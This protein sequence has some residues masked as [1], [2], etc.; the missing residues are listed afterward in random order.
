MTPEQQTAL[1]TAR[2]LLDLGY[3]LD[4]VLTNPLI[5]PELREFVRTEL[6]REENITLTPARILVRDQNRADWLRGLDRSAWY[7]WPTLRQ[8]LL[9]TKGWDSSV[10]RSLDDSSDRILRQLEPPST[11]RFD[12]RGLVLGFVQSGKTANF[13]AVAAKAADAGYRLV[14]VLSGIDNSLRRQ[15]NIRLKRELVGYPDNRPGSVHLPPMGLQWHE[16]TRDDLRGDFRP[17]FANHAA[18]QGSQPVLLVVKKNGHV[19]RRLLT[20]LRQAP[21]EVRHTLPVLV[22]DDEADLASV[23][24]CGTY[25][26]AEDPPDTSDPDYEPP[27]AI[28]GL[29]RELLGLFE[30]RVYVAYTATPYAN[31]LIP[32]DT[33][34]PRVRND[35]YPKDFIVDLPKPAGY[36]G[37]EEIFGRM[38]GAT[39]TE[40]GG[41]DVIREMT[42]EDIA[43]LDQDQL[44]ASLEAAL[45]DF[46]LAGAARAQRGQDNTPATMLIHT[47]QLIMV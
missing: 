30:R 28:N 1:R 6:Q 33:E 13:T 5:T 14:I 4:I 32:H 38:D 45:L 40:V 18:L 19:L 10:L 20:W 43:A 21:V 44:P 46:V 26:T 22:I 17:G 3:S 15:T 47:S 25:Q 12:I 11:E 29:I 41:L 16:F 37:A 27:S 24:T 36:F 8:Y 7:Y 35:L 23:D 2:A 42:D 34:D 31:I 39:G 9:T